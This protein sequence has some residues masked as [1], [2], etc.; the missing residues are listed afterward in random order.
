MGD[1]DSDDDL[2]ALISNATS[3]TAPAKKA[4]QAAT[5]GAGQAQ[6]DKAI[7]GK[8]GSDGGVDL[9]AMVK[10]AKRREQ[11]R[12]AAEQEIA[13][14]TAAKAEEEARERAA[15]TAATDAPAGEA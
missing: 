5:V 1:S 14:L 4:A 11:Q 9:E 8:R 13:R 7:L 3:R 10:G 6:L 2:D 12:E 15:A